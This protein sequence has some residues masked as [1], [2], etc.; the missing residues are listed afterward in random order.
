MSVGSG[1][2]VV[3]CHVCTMVARTS[4]GAKIIGERNAL[5]AALLS[6]EVSAVT[7]EAAMEGVWP[8]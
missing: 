7:M 3:E 6:P 8:P 4:G 1:S 5:R 2:D